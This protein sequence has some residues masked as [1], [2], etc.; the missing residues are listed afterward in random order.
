MK[1]TKLRQII[2][3]SKLTFYAFAFNA[4]VA[5]SLLAS[6]SGAQ[7]IKSVK[8][9]SVSLNLNNP[10]IGQ[11]FHAI[12]GLTDYNFSYNRDDVDSDARISGK[13]KKASV[14]NVLLEI[15][16][17]SSLKFR[18]VNNSIHVSPKK[19]EAKTKEA[20]EIII[21]GKTIT[22]RVTSA[23]SPSSQPTGLPGV[24][25]IVKGTTNG[26][27]TDLEG[28]YAID[29]PEGNDILVFSSIGYVSQEVPINGRSVI[30][31]SM[32]EDV[33]SLEEIVVV[34]YGTQKRSDVT[35]SV[36][37]VS[38][39]DLVDRPVANVGQA[40]QNKVAGVFVIKQA[41][42]APGGNPMIRIRG[43]NS[44]NTS[45]DPLFVVDGVVGVR[46]ALQSLN[47]NEIVS[48]DILKDASATAIYG[49]RGANGVVIIETKRGAAGETQVNYTGSVSLSTMT[50]HNY[51]VT[52]DQMMYLYEQAFRNTPKF[53]TLDK[54]KDFRGGMGT[55]LSWS[56]MPHLFEQVQQGDYFMDLI[57][58]DGN[59]YKPRFYSDWEDLAFNNSVSTDQHI[60]VSGGTEN[61]KFS[62]ALGYT[63][64]NGLMKES[65]FKRLNARITGDMNINDW[66][67]LSTN[68]SYANTKQS[69]T[70]GETRTISET[71][72]FLPIKYPNDPEYGLYAG[73]W[74]T[75][76]DFPVGENWKNILYTLDQRN[77][78]YLDNQ[79]TGSVILNAQITKDLS[80]KTDFSVDISAYD[81]R[82]YQGT[83]QGN[84][85]GRAEGNN[86]RFGYWQNQN[87][88]N[89]NKTIGDHN[90]SALLGLSWSEQTEDYLFSQGRG[91]RDKFLPVQ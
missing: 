25:V 14:A 1:K 24:N 26:S 12:E 3:L 30:D 15:S 76:R 62:L 79:F 20:L 19:D 22:G 81:G 48:M 71:W 69:R 91:V 80:F 70:D 29:V 61:A 36:S 4:M 49:T 39:K 68:V 13:F 18:Q 86:R 42:G 35:G 72:P 59:Y 75:G 85:S 44:I 6:S 63:D 8:E 45:G 7:S 46:N 64:Q 37:S 2:M 66:L 33:T 16:K 50:R 9:T 38:P 41:A 5:G 23:E 55:G 65:Y 34:G 82:W 60:D 73:T 27:V 31:I 90:I 84:E 56:E 74:S 21:Q 54:T 47:P 78:Y 67:G 52:T 83:Y 88:F 87:Y 10:S 57:G 28:N 40:M 11:L 43:T 17:Q 32:A 53:G 51:T 58:N 89:Y 77:G